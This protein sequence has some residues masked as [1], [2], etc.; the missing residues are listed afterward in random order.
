MKRPWFFRFAGITNAGTAVS[1]L[2]ERMKP[3]QWL[4][5]LFYAV[6]N[7]SGESITVLWGIEAMGA[8]AGINSDTAATNAATL[9]GFQTSPLFLRE[10]E[11]FGAQVTG[12]AD[13]GP[14]TLIASGW[15]H[16]GD[17]VANEVAQEIQAAQAAGS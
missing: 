7:A 17:Y 2:S 6:Y 16:E 3:G 10:G 5:V 12:T 9:N 13:K 14:F 15:L 1:V 8:F 11:Q 4:E